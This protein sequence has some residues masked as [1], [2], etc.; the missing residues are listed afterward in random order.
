MNDLHLAFTM[1]QSSPRTGSL[2]FNRCLALSLS[3]CL[4]MS[5]Y[6][7]SLAVE[8][9]R[10][11]FLIYFSFTVTAC[12]DVVFFDESI[13]AKLNRYTF[14]LQTLDT[15]FLLNNSHRHIKAFV[16]PSPDLSGLSNLVW[17]IDNNS[18][19]TSKKIGFP[20]LRYR[21]VVN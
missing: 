20:R 19:D 6:L 7:I 16:A 3:L 13:D 15:P 2:S 9:I 14:R 4:L 1:F 21:C 5:V 11:T 12:I 8:V 17:C 18:I 10:S